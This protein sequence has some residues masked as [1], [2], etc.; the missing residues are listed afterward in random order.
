MAIALFS[1]ELVA[2]QHNDNNNNNNNNN[3]NDKA[4]H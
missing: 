4:G 2:N 1:L 3:N